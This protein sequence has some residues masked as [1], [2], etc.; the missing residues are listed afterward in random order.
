MILFI[1]QNHFWTLFGGR[2]SQANALPRVHLSW[3]TVIVIKL[4]LQD[5]DLIKT[6]HGLLRFLW[7]Y[8]KEN[9][10]QT[11]TDWHRESWCLVKNPTL[12]HKYNSPHCNRETC[13]RG[14][15]QFNAKQSHTKKF[16]M[17]TIS[18]TCWVT[19]ACCEVLSISSP[20][21]LTRSVLHSSASSPHGAICCSESDM[22]SS[23]SNH[24]IF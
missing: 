21:I 3:I 16:S 24:H 18:C 8:K 4:L 19:T 22:P 7:K 13:C 11:H 9:N 15:V 20:S 6:L 17:A 5:K 1:L 23:E 2:C 10:T 12:L 14:F